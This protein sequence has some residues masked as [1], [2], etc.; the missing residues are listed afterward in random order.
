MAGVA[1][2][3]FDRACCSDVWSAA[4]MAFS[5]DRRRLINGLGRQI[6]MAEFFL[7][8]VSGS[9]QDVCTQVDG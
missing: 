3:V 9:C 6:R 4:P 1:L 2:G 8:L 5:D 7:F